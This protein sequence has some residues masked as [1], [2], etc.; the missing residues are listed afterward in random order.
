MNTHEYRRA[1]SY[2]RRL[3]NDYRDIVHDA[4]LDYFKRTKQDLFDAP[5]RTIV[6]TVR[7]H[8]YNSIRKNRFMYEGEY[9]QKRT[10]SLSE[11]DV[12]AIDTE[13]KFNLYSTSFMS[14]IVINDEVEQ[15]CKRLTPV[16]V[17]VFQQLVQG[18]TIQDIAKNKN[19]NQSSVRK[20][21]EY[22]KER[23]QK[24]ITR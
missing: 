16:Q 15:V 19:V 3:T 4:Y 18:Y 17:D 22:I 7:N 23:G 21:V 6:V 14:E 8:Y 5:N 9:H 24:V 1:C 10:Y 20:S 13:V 2:A 12:N 11:T